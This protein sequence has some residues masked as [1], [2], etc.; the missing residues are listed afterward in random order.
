MLNMH[1]YECSSIII[2]AFVKSWE[3]LFFQPVVFSPLQNGPVFKA[4]DCVW[5]GISSFFHSEQCRHELY[6]CSGKFPWCSWCRPGLIHLFYT[7]QLDLL[8]Y[9]NLIPYESVRYMMHILLSAENHTGAKLQHTVCHS[10][11]IYYRSYT[12]TFNNV[13]KCHFVSFCT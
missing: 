12:F 7:T 8:L 10:G 3:L 6:R 2:I 9:C 4:E 11:E 13:C 1:K 5:L